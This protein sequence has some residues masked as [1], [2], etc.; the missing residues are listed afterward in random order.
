MMLLEAINPVVIINGLC[1]RQSVIKSLDYGDKS[2][3][4][5]KRILVKTG[6]K[7]FYVSQVFNTGFTATSL[8]QLLK[9]IELVYPCKKYKHY[10]TNTL[11]A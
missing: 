11:A 2:F 5:V 3:Y 7:P 6:A 8:E 1:F 9:D 4:I 10:G